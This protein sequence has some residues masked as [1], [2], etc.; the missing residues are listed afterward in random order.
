MA[1]APEKRLAQK[2]L[3]EEMT[4][5]IHGQVGLAIAQRASEVL[6]GGSMDG[7]NADDLVKVFAN[8]PSKELPLA[9][10]KDAG[11]LEVA[12]ASGLC[13]SKGEARRLMTEGGFYINNNRVTDAAAKV[14]G[15]M[16]IDGRVLVMRAGKKNY[17]LVKVNH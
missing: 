13:K 7:M 12:M 6:F 11:L 15:D 16:L 3:A 10:V 8:V 4:R 1:A 14:T 2:T 9:S 17:C 5:T